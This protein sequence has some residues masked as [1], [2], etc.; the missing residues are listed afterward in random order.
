MV[1]PANVVP[2]GTIAC[3][4]NCR[5]GGFA[6]PLALAPIAAATA[7][8]ATATAATLLRIPLMATP[9]D[10]GRGRGDL[11]APRRRGRARRPR[12]AHRSP[13]R[14]RRWLSRPR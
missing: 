10:E 2:V 6:P 9:E 1:V 14:R 4:R 12:Y 11:T 8:T 3:P 7:A 13:W 5:P